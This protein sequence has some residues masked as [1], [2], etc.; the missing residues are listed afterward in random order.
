MRRITLIP[1]LLLCVFPAFAQ[2]AVIQSYEESFTLQSQTSGVHKV[3]ATVL[4]MN[5][6]GLRQA[7]PV[8]YT[9]SFRSLGSF[10]AETSDTGGKKVKSGKGD[11][12]TVSISTG[13]ASDSFVSVFQPSG[14][15]PMT[16]W[17]TLFI[18]RR[19]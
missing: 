9:D 4:V 6:D 18:F 2:N 16:V 3:S 11:I 17:S 12:Q 19:E 14:K 15:Y 1:V 8:I 5:K 13:L 7:T 10:K